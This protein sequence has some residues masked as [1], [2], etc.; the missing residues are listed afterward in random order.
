MKLGS[1]RISV[2][3][4]IVSCIWITLSDEVLFFFHGS[5]NQ[6]FF[7]L[8]SSIKGLL[9][10]FVSA[11]LLWHLIKLNYK[12]LAQSEKQYR[13]IY[14][15]SP[16]PN[17][18]Y[19]F[20]SLKFVSV[21]A[22]AIKQY[23]YSLEEFLSMTILDIRP[24]YEQE[25]VLEAL[26]SVSPNIRQSGTWIHRKADGTLL[27]VLINS[28]QIVFKGK[29]CVMVTVQ[30][31]SETIIYENKLKELNQDLIEEKKKLSDTQQVARIGGW[32][33]YIAD[34]KVTWSDEM[35]IIA[36]VERHTNLNLHEVFLQQ[37]RPKEKAAIVEAFSL[38]V[39]TGKQ[40]DVTHPIN[41]LSGKER[42][43]RQLA[44]LEYVNGQPYKVIGSTQDVTQ[45]KQLET[46]RNR[47][48]F[49]LEDTL[50]N[51]SEGFY[52]LS[53]DLVFTNVNARFELE[54]GLSKLDIIGKEFT[55]VFPGSET[56]LTYKQ[57]QKV[58]AE[59]VSVKFEAY[60]RHFKQWHYVSAYPTEEGIAVYF[61]DIT[62]KKQNEINLNEVIERYEIVTKATQD[63]V[64]DYDVAS[65]SLIF[66]TRISELLNCDIDDI[67]GDLH[68]WRSLIHPED[69]ESVLRS[70]KKVIADKK[71][72]WRHEYR[73]KCGNDVYKYIY[74][75]AYYLYNDANEVIRIIGAVKDIDELK[76][77][78][79]ENKRLADIITKINNMVVVM[80]PNH[81]ITWVNKAFEEYTGY[82]YAEV[83]GKYPNEFL[84]G[85]SISE[86]SMKEIGERKSK[87]ETFTIDIKHRL[88]NGH[89]QWVNVEYTP[90]FNE[91]VKHIGYIAVH[92]N[93][94]ERKD[95]EEK[96]YKQNKILQ[97]ISWLS[98]HEIRKPVASILGLAYLA[99]DN[100]NEAE[101]DQIIEMI[102][103]CAEELDG[104][105]HTITDKISNELYVGKHKI[106]LLELE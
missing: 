10:A 44:R 54:T 14:E 73:I 35:Y 52:T 71:P 4:L 50:N 97:E 12:R 89:T 106:D 55:E 32:E 78:N 22:S 5:I 86:Q 102:N 46:E 87:L 83:I 56:R 27:H 21:N 105:V 7:Q 68:W 41:L 57:Y 63:V 82:A 17:W 93:I 37:I 1:V 99:K 16:I 24:S 13:L 9:F 38:L 60:W 59:K 53:K 26:R 65:D 77:V 51:I 101:K 61:T 92:N 2:I 42:Y 28:Q 20:E 30:D 8:I 103:V 96:I 76:R 6:Y 104:I 69:R 67:G 40:L 64:Y 74:S 18:I 39:K 80:D 15:S 81:R 34:Q 100:Q 95:K 23:G 90:L 25:K 70:Q 49:S 33:Y 72:I 84:G 75:Q 62:E 88:R 66:N 91:C 58:L 45:L 48:L 47:Y 85:D 31:I 3:Y 98:S 43:L 29:I 79:E 94:T 11:I 19:N 36:E